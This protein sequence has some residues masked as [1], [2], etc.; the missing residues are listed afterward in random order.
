ML[1]FRDTLIENKSHGKILVYILLSKILLKILFYIQ[2]Y[3]CT[4]NYVLS[5]P[6]RSFLSASKLNSLTFP[7]VCFTQAT[8]VSISNSIVL[9]L[10]FLWLPYLYCRIHSIGVI[11]SEVGA[12]TETVTLVA[13]TTSQIDSASKQY[14]MS[15]RAT[16]SSVPSPFLLYLWANQVWHLAKTG[17]ATK[18]G[19]T[20]VSRGEVTNGFMNCKVE[21]TVR[22][23]IYRTIATSRI[24]HFS[25]E[26][27]T[28]F[29]AQS[30][31]RTVE[32]SN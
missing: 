22:T 3:F 8:H 7:R 30:R 5:R 27:W 32:M 10:H 16:S 18:S 25:P 6:H 31:K 21:F 13:V 26:V 9:P 2:T 17:G 20:G 28:T 12:T 15:L 23:I 4:N 14:K 11:T 24:D 29:L 19:T 1:I